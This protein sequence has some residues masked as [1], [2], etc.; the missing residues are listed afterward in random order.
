M[1]RSDH[2]GIQAVRQRAEAAGNSLGQRGAA[3]QGCGRPGRR[4]GGLEQDHHLHC[5]EKV[6]GEGA[7]GAHG[8]G[9]SL[10]ARHYPGGGPAAGDPGAH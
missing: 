9:L 3:G 1:Q 8:A 5:A 6:R 7:G 2:H 10:P 4:C